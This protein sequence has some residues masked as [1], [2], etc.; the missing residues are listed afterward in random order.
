MRH[1]SPF[2][3]KERPSGALL[4]FQDHIIS[5]ADQVMQRPGASCFATA[6]KN[7]HHRLAGDGPTARGRSLAHPSM[8]GALRPASAASPDG[9]RTITDESS[10]PGT[11]NEIVTPL[12]G[13][14]RQPHGRPSRSDRHSMTIGSVALLER[15]ST[16]HRRAAP[17]QADRCRLTTSRCTAPSASIACH[18]SESSRSQISH[19]PASRCQCRVIAARAKQR[20]GRGFRSRLHPVIMPGQKKNPVDVR[21][22]L[23]K[24]GVLSSKPVKS[25]CP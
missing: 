11:L 15:S 10:D 6:V 13:R 19:L 22:I 24:L 21:N 7:A 9:I 18:H 4:S 12:T 23:V 2:K 25:P 16:L 14:N 8:A 20:A 3:I 1:L 5:S 17:G